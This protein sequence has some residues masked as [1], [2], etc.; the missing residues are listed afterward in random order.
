MHRFEKMFRSTGV[1]PKKKPLITS[2]K[3]L[4]AAQVLSIY[5]P[6][7]PLTVS[8]DALSYGIGAVILQQDDKNNPHPVCNVS[9]MLSAT[10]R[11]YAQINKK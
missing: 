8:C 3:I 11:H 2:K 4:N 9:R 1:N 6:L 10:E 5:N 7:Q